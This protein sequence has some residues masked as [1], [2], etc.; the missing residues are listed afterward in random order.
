MAM[1]EERWE[2]QHQGWQQ[3]CSAHGVES[4]GVASTQVK[5]CP[6]ND[7]AG[8]GGE[9]THE[10]VEAKS[11]PQVR[12]EAPKIEDGAGA[13]TSVGQTKQGGADQ[14]TGHVGE[15]TTEYNC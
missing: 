11:R 9:A 14:L 7:G 5:Y 10:E 13:V 15:I 3:D 6:D 8:Q 12:K 4:Q 2:R 1:I